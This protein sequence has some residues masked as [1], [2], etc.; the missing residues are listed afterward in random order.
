M[1]ISE[2]FFKT[3]ASLFVLFVAL[4]LAA[5]FLEGTLCANMVE[6]PA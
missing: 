6:T 1:R 2:L 5:W 3:S 4:G